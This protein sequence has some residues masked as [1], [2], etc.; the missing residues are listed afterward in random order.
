MDTLTTE[1]LTLEPLTV[2]HAAELW[3]ALGDARLYAFIPRPPPASHDELARRFARISVRCAPCRDEQWLNWIVRHASTAIGRVEVTIQA[4]RTALLAYELVH[5]AW[6]HGYAAEACAAVI[7]HLFAEFPLARIVA[8]IDARN[9][10]SIA[11]ALR[12]GFRHTATQDGEHTYELLTG[13]R[14]SRLP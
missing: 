5:D 4:D 9:T 14:A 8:E 10:R 13:E 7:E 3:P 6:G 12:L 11:L 2:A 1:R